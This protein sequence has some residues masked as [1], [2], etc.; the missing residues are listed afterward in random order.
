MKMF[1][2]IIVSCV[3]WAFAGSTAFADTLQNA[4]I[5]LDAGRYDLAVAQG[6]MLGSAD[7]LVLAT[8]ALN[9]QLFLGLAER[10]TKT[11]KRAMKLAEAAL[12]LDPDTK[13]AQL[14]YAIAYGFYGR[15]VSSF[16]AWRKNLPTKIRTAIDKS[17]IAA[18]DDYR[19]H[20]LKGA[21]HLNLLYRAGGF[22]VEKRY[23]ANPIE[24]ITHFETALA[25][26]PDDIIIGSTYIM[27]TY[28]LE[29][30]ARA[31]QTKKWLKT[32]VLPASP[33]NATEQQVQAQM[34]QVYEG[35][36][37]NE[38]LERAEAFVNQ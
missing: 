16:K 7:G 18:P 6:T 31:A 9:A 20:A 26:N 12:A 38:A 35:F 13:D 14:Q 10:K 15:H 3:L 25:N 22:D 24:G 29:P 4:R 23:G 1:S 2:T 30:Q 36:A 33:K 19:A 32:K 34:R 21:W 11:A 8:E 28:V 17:A 37:T 5:S 27:L